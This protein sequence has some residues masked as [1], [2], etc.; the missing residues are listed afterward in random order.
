MSYLKGFINEY[1]DYMELH[2]TKNNCS[3]APSILTR[4]K[5]LGRI[6]LQT[7]NPPKVMKFLQKPKAEVLQYAA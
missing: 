6:L 4:R 5:R 2:D 7:K 1:M 3:D